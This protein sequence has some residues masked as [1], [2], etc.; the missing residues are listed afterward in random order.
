MRQGLDVLQRVNRAARSRQA[1]ADGHHVG[2][3]PAHAREHALGK[4]PRCPTLTRARALASSCLSRARR[5]LKTV[6]LI[7]LETHHNDLQMPFQVAL[8]M[9][10]QG[11]G[12]PGADVSSHQ[13]QELMP[14][15]SQKD[16][17]GDHVIEAGVTMPFNR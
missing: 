14:Q 12:M 16:S 1:I 13:A 17:R 4:L 8:K 10:N 9:G 3:S 2:N 15:Q 6:S 5:R 11:L 7:A